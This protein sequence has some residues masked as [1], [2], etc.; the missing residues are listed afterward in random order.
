MGGCEQVEKSVEAADS[1]KK[2]GFNM[3]PQ[4]VDLHLPAFVQSGGKYT[5]NLEEAAR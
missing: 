4:L 2:L 1:L 3:D 5:V